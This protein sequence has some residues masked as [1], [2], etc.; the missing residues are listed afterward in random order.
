MTSS[1]GFR[2]PSVEGRT[3]EQGV[4][5]V[6]QFNRL[7][8]RQIGVLQEHLLHTP[9]SLAEARVI[10]ELANQQQTTATEL[11][12]ELGLD[13]GYLSRMLQAF[14]KRGLISKQ[15][16]PS[17]GRQL[18][19]ALTDQGQEAFAQLNAR[20]REEIGA[21]LGKLAAPDQS[22]LV[23]AMHTIERLLGAQPEHKVPYL[24]RPQQPGDMGWVVQRHGILYSE[25][26]GWNEQFEAFVA[27]IVAQFI[28]RFDPVR[29]RCWVAERNGENVGSVFLVKKSKTVAQLRLLLVEPR[30]RGLGLGTR[31]VDECIR[32]A[33]QAS[34]KKVILWTNDVLQAAR[35]IYE[36]A[37]FLLVEEERHHSFGH[38]LVGQTWELAL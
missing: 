29:E 8:T 16:S 23:D 6:R 34:Y 3:F 15:V 25:E 10:Y 33:R 9:F 36:K 37:G 26:Y 11:G 30:A 21:M 24:L 7:Y 19:L 4:A 12:A 20:S 2:G 35:R 28:R 31:L 18:L 5:A 14:Q 38:D 13:A 27:D 17:D 32:F 22:R 1:Y